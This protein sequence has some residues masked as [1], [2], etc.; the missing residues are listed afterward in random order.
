[1]AETV[2]GRGRGAGSERERERETSVHSVLSDSRAHF[3]FLNALE[4]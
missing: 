3:L 1:M 2:R 4:A